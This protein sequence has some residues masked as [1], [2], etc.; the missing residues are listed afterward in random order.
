MFTAPV[1]SG[2]GARPPARRRRRLKAFSSSSSSVEGGAPASPAARPAGAPPPPPPKG[3]EQQQQQRTSVKGG[4]PGWTQCEPFTVAGAPGHRRGAGHAPLFR[5]SRRAARP[6]T[7]GPACL[8][9][10]SR[11]AL[12]LFGPR[13]GEGLCFTDLSLHSSRPGPVV[14][15]PRA[16]QLGLCCY[17][18]LPPGSAT[19]P[20]L[21]PRQRRLGSVP[22]VPR[23]AGQPGVCDAGAG[24]GLWHS[25]L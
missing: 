22:P 18:L 14:Y 23:P 10:S 5:G 7:V 17:L 9:H 20:G 3:V 8:L 15:G 2:W 12:F 16:G 21:W 19:R 4:A 25:L 13:A 24:P 1:S 11:P 6:A